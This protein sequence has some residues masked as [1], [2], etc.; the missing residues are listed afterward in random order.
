[1]EQLDHLRRQVSAYRLGAMLWRLVEEFPTSPQM[2][3][4]LLRHRMHRD[5]EGATTEE[6]EA[7]FG[8]APPCWMALPNHV[9]PRME[10]IAHH[11]YVVHQ[12]QTVTAGLEAFE[13]TQ[14]VWDPRALFTAVAVDGDDELWQAIE[15]LVAALHLTQLH[16]D[17]QLEA[18]HHSDIPAD[19]EV[20]TID[21]F[22]KE[23]QTV[24]SILYSRGRAALGNALE[25][26]HRFLQTRVDNDSFY[27]ALRFWCGIHRRKQ[28]AA[29]LMH[30]ADDDTELERLCDPTQTVPNEILPVPPVP[31]PKQEAHWKPAGGIL[32]PVNM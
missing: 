23:W 27:R 28:I 32:V 14:R 10:T 6:V 15:T 19:W 29:V 20:T 4:Q 2:R 21:D 3:H 16:F 24:E 26:Y 30:E 31:D 17:L 13:D 9:W 12:L 8:T 7:V 18:L 11:C 5:E 25:S 1:M 22:R